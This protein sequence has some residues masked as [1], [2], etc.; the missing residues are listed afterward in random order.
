[1]ISEQERKAILAAGKPEPRDVPWFGEVNF[2]GWY[3]EEEIEAA[4]K[5]IRDS[6]HW[7]KGLG[8]RPKEVTQFEEKLAEYCGAKYA[9]ALTNCGAG[10]DLAA[11]ALGLGPGDEVICPAIN[12]K[13]SQLV[14]IDRGAKV[15]FCETDPVT[16]NLDPQDVERRMTSRTRAI[17]PVHQTGLSAPMDELEDIANRHPHP[18]YGPP[19]IIGD[20]A[21]AAGAGYK[22]GKVGGTGWATS[23]SFHSQ[24][25][26]TTLGEGGALVTN[27][28]ELAEKVRDMIFYGGEHGWGMNY[29]MC[30][31][32]AAVGIVQLKRLDEMIAKRRQVALRR[33]KL[34]DGVSE[35]ILPSEPHG[36]YH[37]FYV[38][39]ILVKK[40]WAGKRRDEILRIMEEKF[41]IVCSVTNRPV[42]QRWPY[43]AEKCGTPNLPITED[44]GQRLFCPP[45]HPQFTEEQEM[46]VVAS[47]LETIDTIGSSDEG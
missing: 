23:F 24:K 40:E 28:K 30:K 34:L 9:L 45:I 10:L 16:L 36:Y 25:L 29:R 41:G 37:A 31:V 3:T 19:K 8:P 2:G 21:R 38:Y 39:P 18:V 22:G 26:M 47:L 42:Y 35:L 14:V 43:I 4:V 5:A 1:M 27:D 20:A 13:A 32:Q 12:Y 44:I 15:V 17:I 11:R 7:S 33:N 46:Y 6:M